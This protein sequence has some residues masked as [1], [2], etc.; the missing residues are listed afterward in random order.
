MLNLMLQ[1]NTDDVNTVSGSTLYRDVEQ[2]ITLNTTSHYTNESLQN[3][4]FGG[5][6]NDNMIGGAMGDRL[7]GMGGID[8]L[9]GKGERSK[10]LASHYFWINAVNKS[11]SKLPTLRRIYGNNRL[12]R[13]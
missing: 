3:I 10:G 11:V 12:A 9:L 1:R 7:Y 4:V 6:G 8:A 13:R 2:H 5:A